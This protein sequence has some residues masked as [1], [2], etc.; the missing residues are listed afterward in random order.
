MHAQAS[1]GSRTS[2][3]DLKLEYRPQ[4]RSKL[5]SIALEVR[6]YIIQEVLADAEVICTIEKPAKLPEPA[7]EADPPTMPE[8]YSTNAP[9]A[10]GKAQP[11]HHAIILSCRQLAMECRSFLPKFAL[12]KLNGRGW[13]RVIVPR[14]LLNN[15]YR[16][17]DRSFS[18]QIRGY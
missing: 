18:K 12:L 17:C 4:P 15:P 5:L 6:E 14:Q 9:K 13:Y 1:R 11:Q 7:T 8:R 10:N 2:I 16:E 3:L